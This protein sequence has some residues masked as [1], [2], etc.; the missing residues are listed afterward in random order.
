[1]PFGIDCSQPSIDV[2]VVLALAHHV[3]EV[4]DLIKARDVRH[5]RASTDIDDNRSDVRTS[6]PACTSGGDTNGAWASVRQIFEGTLDPAIGKT[7]DMIPARF[8]ALHIDFNVAG[9]EAI[10]GTAADHVR[11]IRTR[12]QG[13]R[14]CSAVLTQVP[15]KWPR[16]MSR[17]S[18]GLAWPAPMM[19]ASRAVI[20]YSSPT[21]GRARRRF[22]ALSSR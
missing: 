1:V 19:I 2:T 8:D 16:S 18:A 13:F 22:W 15:P 14:R 4:I 10:V 3:G 9:A 21:K 17:A 5:R 6:L 11:G 20:F 7:D 12:D